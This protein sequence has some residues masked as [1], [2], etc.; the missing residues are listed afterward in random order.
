VLKA[1]SG[2]VADLA[3]D[4]L[5]GPIP[6]VLAQDPEDVGVGVGVAAVEA[7]LVVEVELVR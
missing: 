1:S 7:V 6:V 2:H 5:L 4:L 3:E